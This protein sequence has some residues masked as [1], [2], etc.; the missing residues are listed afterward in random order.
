[1]AHAREIEEGIEIVDCRLSER[2]VSERV[3]AP[4]TPYNPGVMR[5]I[6]PPSYKSRLVWPS[7]G[8]SH[9][10]YI[11]SPSESINEQLGES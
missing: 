11:L 6:C 10:P 4:K 1:M 8:L 5:F 2:G 9:S 3:P 7:L